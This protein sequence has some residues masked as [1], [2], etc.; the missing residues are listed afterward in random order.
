[1]A[2][3]GYGMSVEE[4]REQAL[5]DPEVQAILG[6]PVMQTILQQMQTDPGAAQKYVVRGLSG[7]CNAPLASCY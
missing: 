3:S 7:K 4:R 5:K 6:D 2:E 1:M